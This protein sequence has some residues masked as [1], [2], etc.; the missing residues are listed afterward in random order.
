MTERDPRW[1]KVYG[2]ILPRNQ[3][4]IPYDEQEAEIHKDFFEFRIEVPLDGTVWYCVQ[5]IH[6]DDL[7][8]ALPVVNMRGFILDE[9]VKRIDKYLEEAGE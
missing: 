4:V 8:D 9:M 6:K 3:V 5:L 7:A 2:H 1:E